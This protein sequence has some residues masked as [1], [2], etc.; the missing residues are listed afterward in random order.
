MNQVLPFYDGMAAHYHLIFDDWEAAIRRQ[1]AIIASLL[2][3][4]ETNVRILDCAC[5]IGTQ[6]LAVA[7]LGFQVDASDLSPAQLN[8]SSW[9]GCA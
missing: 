6:S 3:P 9:C 5:G 8:P 4:A 7:K 1:G 2:P